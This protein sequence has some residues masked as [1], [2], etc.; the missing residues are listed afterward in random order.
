[1]RSPSCLTMGQ[2]PA[3]PSLPPGTLETETSLKRCCGYSEGVSASQL[4]PLDRSSSTCRARS[5]QESCR[6]GFGGNPTTLDTDQ[7]PGSP[8]LTS[9]SRP[10]SASGILGG[11]LASMT[12]PTPL[13]GHGSPPAPVKVGAGCIPCLSS[14]VLSNVFLPF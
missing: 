11:Q 2:C 6:A 10:L 8:P 1:M 3:L 7:A 9:L 14:R 4:G 5:Q 13:L 12:P